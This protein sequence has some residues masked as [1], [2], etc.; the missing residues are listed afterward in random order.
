MLEFDVKLRV[1]NQDGELVS[2]FGPGTAALLKGVQEHSSLN[3]AAKSMRMAYSKAWKSINQTEEQF[4]FALI[5]RKKS[6]GSEL[7]LKGLQLLLLYDEMTAAA[8]K[9]VEDV[10]IESGSEL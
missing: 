8:L 4:G 9:A 3:K 5:D 10:Y 6:Y 2:S 1:M 7:T